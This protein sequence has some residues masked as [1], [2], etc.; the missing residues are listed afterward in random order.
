MACVTDVVYPTI[1]VRFDW[2]CS[3]KSTQMKDDVIGVK[4]SRR[5]HS[6]FDIIRWKE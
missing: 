4:D 2:G 6:L 5:L 1:G 3:V